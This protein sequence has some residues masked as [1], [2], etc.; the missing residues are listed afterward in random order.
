VYI[1][2]TARV[3]VCLGVYVS[4]CVGVCVWVGGG[5][6]VYVSSPSN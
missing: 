4:G 5:G 3:E 6:G 1:G 2:G